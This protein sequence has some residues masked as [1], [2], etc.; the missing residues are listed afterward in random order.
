MMGRAKA[1]VDWMEFYEDTDNQAVS[2][3]TMPSPSWRLFPEIEEAEQNLKLN[4]LDVVIACHE[5]KQNDDETEK[6]KEQIKIGALFIGDYSAACDRDI[7][8][9]NQ[10]R[11]IVNCGY[12]LKNVFQVTVAYKTLPL[13]DT[14]DAPLLEYV[15]DATKFIN[16]HRMQGEN[17]LVHCMMGKSRSAAVAMAYLIQ[18]RQLQVQEAFDFLKSKRS[19]V[20]PNF[21]FLQQLHK[22]WEQEEQQRQTNNGPL[23]T[24]AKQ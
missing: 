23:L 12:E 10:I 14:D 6:K 8:A 24:E 1:I 4:H 2:T 15:S 21:G 3:Q 9:S 20:Q 7:I 5:K 17:V 22:L 11:A 16:D 18:N 13:D 19:V